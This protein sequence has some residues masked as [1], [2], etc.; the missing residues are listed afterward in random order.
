MEISE[1]RKMN[2]LAG[3]NT[4]NLGIGQLPDQLPQALKIRGVEAFEQG[5]TRYTSNQGSVELRALVAAYHSEKNG[6]SY[7]ADQVIITNGAEGALWNIFTV[8]LDRGEEV[9]IP[10]IA[11]QFIRLLPNSTMV[12]LSPI[13]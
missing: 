3:E 8:Y 13:N 10:E 5:R 9:L 4:L 1:I 11:F 2:A 12:W 6:R 7:K